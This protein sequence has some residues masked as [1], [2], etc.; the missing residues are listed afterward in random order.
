MV[1]SLQQDF[2]G[3]GNSDD[4]KRRAAL[5]LASVTAKRDDVDD[6]CGTLRELLDACGLL[7]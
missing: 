4:E 2:L 7:S 1:D 5:A 3:L 6:T